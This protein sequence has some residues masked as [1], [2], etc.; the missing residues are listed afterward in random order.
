MFCLIGFYGGLTAV[1]AA[2][3]LLRN[4]LSKSLFGSRF[5]GVPLVTFH[6]LIVAAAFGAVFLQDQWFRE[7]AA[8]VSAKSIGLLVVFGPMIWVGIVAACFNRFVGR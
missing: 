2:L 8:S 7:L 1:I 4:R 3:L 6:L 5:W